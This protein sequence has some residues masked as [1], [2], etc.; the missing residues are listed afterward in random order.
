M[1]LQSSA[2]SQSTQMA[3]SQTF[4]AFHRLYTEYVQA[5]IHGPPH[6]AWLNAFLQSS[7]ESDTTD[8]TLF[9]SE[10]SS[11]ARTERFAGDCS[12]LSPALSHGLST[13]E[14]VIVCHQ[15]S[16]SINRDVVDFLGHTL[17]L[18]PR[19]LRHH[20]DYEE[21]GAEE[22]CPA[23][24]GKINMNERRVASGRWL[25]KTRKA[26]A[27]LPSEISAKALHIGICKDCMSFC[28]KDR[29]SEML[30]LITMDLR[31]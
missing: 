12:G 25:Q 16:C 28:M 27:Y 1:D 6:F 23:G 3:E 19:F 14:A 7:P 5:H 30:L 11:R 18:D 21:F 29:I 9:W 8:V 31:S 10:E 4:P 26:P 17:K 20:F 13:L 15:D 24:I 2:D 22:G